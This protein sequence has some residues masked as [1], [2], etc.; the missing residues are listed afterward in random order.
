MASISLSPEPPE[1]F[2]LMQWPKSE[3]WDSQTG[4][5]GTYWYRIWVTRERYKDQINV[6]YQRH[7]D[8]MMLPYPMPTTGWVTQH[9]TTLSGAELATQL[10]LW[11]IKPSRTTVERAD[12]V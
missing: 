5:P 6:Y 8:S 10:E 3:G 2:T 7:K 11:G 1:S 4:G 9:Y 12:D